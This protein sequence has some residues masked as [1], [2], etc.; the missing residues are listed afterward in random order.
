MTTRSRNALILALLLLAAAATA[1]PCICPDDGTG[2]VQLPPSCASGFA[3]QMV[4]VDGLPPGSTLEI[5]AELS[6]FFNRFSFPG[7]DL[8]GEVHTF[9]G[10]LHWDL[11]GTGDYAGF[12]RTMVIPVSGVMHTGPR[13]PG[14]DVQQFDQI[15]FNLQG[16]LFGDPDFCELIVVAGNSNGL[17]SPGNCKLTKLPDGN[18]NVDS[19]FDITYRIE[20][21]GCPG[22]A[23]DGLAG[24]TT[25]TK[26]FR[27]GEEYYPPVDHSCVL[28]DN[29]L[30][31][32][33]IPP[34]CPDGFEGPMQIVDGLPPGTTLDID[35][36]LTDFIQVF[37]APGGTL[38]GMEH[39]FEGTLHWSVTGTGDLAAFA[40][41]LA[42][43]VDGEIH[44]G[45][46]NPGDPVQ[47][48]DQVLWNLQGELFGDPDFCFLRVNAGDANGLPSPGLC[49]LTELPSGDFAVDSFFDI[50][51]EIEFAGCPGGPL[52]DF[53]G[54]TPGTERFQAGEPYFPPVDH[55]CIL[56]DNGTG[57]VDLPPECPDGYQGLMRIV[58]GLPPGSTIEIDATL[59]DFY[60]VIPSSGGTLGGEV[61]QC[62]A[63]L[64]WVMTGTGDYTGFGRNIAVPVACEMHTAPRTPGDPVQ[65]FDQTLFLMTGQLF[66][67]PDF[68]ELIV[69]AGDAAGL[70]SPGQS[71][72][73]RLPSGDFA[74]DS[75]FDITYQID[76]QG[77]PGS[78]LEGLAG[79]TLGTHRFRAGEPYVTAV[80]DLGDT[81]ALL[82]RN[83]PNPFNP[84]TTIV[85][86]VPAAAGLVSLDIYDLRGQHVRS[87]VRGRLAEGVRT[88]NWAGDDATGRQVA[89]GV[90]LCALRTDRGVEFRKMALI[91]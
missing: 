58:D 20:F 15:L 32:V 89:A 6:G 47:D 84:I 74:V 50:T 57:T 29:G 66:G 68:C 22:G 36:T 40:S 9:E 1:T 60:N 59:T 71:T 87:L 91:K 53:V 5:D 88:V 24:A 77:C 64:Y 25:D 46:R 52:E 76:F 37:E 79:S 23:L 27:A 43:P 45:P 35:A 7:G 42:I 21:Q 30:G 14:D 10:N 70:P 56:P 2:T 51:Y 26:T 80:P 62:D 75:F 18:F 83:H 55:S 86:E 31:T 39:H 49:T 54:T 90:Y 44:S 28:P 72:L 41:A 19:F 4:I 82:L 85:Y 65:Q 67:D 17:P 3:G 61:F 16:Q 38:G 11:N 73:T 63:T 33:T 78:Q 34:D 48:F 12:N 69:T 8:G 13:T 81:G